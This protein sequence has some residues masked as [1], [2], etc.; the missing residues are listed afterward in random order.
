MS[1]TLEISDQLAELLR[2]LASQRGISVKE[3]GE[4][5][6]AVGLATLAGA[7]EVVDIATSEALRAPGAHAL[8]P[9]PRLIRGTARPLQITFEPAPEGSAHAH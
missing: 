9:S 5:A 6:L 4:Q 3:L 8:L 2:T 7:G 1:V